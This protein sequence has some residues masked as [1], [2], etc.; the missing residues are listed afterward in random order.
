MGR[1][2]TLVDQ[3]IKFFSTMQARGWG[4]PGQSHSDQHQQPAESANVNSAS[5]R[6]LRRR[7]ARDPKPTELPSTRNPNTVSLSVCALYFGFV[8]DINSGTFHSLKYGMLL[9]S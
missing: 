4:L 2:V 5:T 8:S 7:V 1:L 6:R 3:Q 9:G